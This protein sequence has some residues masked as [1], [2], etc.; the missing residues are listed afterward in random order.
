VEELL[1]DLVTLGLAG[2]L[3]LLRLEAATF[4]AVEYDEPSADGRASTFRLRMAW[5]VLGLVL[6][7]AALVVHPAPGGDLLLG[8]GDRAGMLLGGF[9]LGG[10]GTAQAILFARRRYARL[11]MPPLWS[12]PGAVLNAVG[13]ALIDEA[14]FRGLVLGF[15]LLTGIDP[16]LAIVAQALLYVLATRTGAPGRSPYVFALALWMGLAAGWLTTVTGGIGA[17]FLGHA[18]T[19]I[20]VFVCTGHAG[21]PA[22]RGHEPEDSWEYRR[23]PDGWRQAERPGEEARTD[24]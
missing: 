9:A 18:V 2:L 10:I 13:T 21:Q 15:L 19:R 22:A 20:A 8:L 24:R 4:S 23:S 17:A 7:V 14:T 16:A 11:R 12:Y 6:V 1:R 3:C 5:Y